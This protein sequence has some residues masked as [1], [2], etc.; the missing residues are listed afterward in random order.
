MENQPG[1]PRTTDFDGLPAVYVSNSGPA[2]PVGLKL[3]VVTVLRAASAAGQPMGA[4]AVS[5]AASGLFGRLNADRTDSMELMQ[6]VDSETPVG[7]PRGVAALAV[8]VAAAAAAGVGLA[9]DDSC[10]S[11]EG[12]GS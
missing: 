10:E 7:S 9:G 3:H 5:P 11:C 1:A 4:D 8:A 2:S 6:S 12:T